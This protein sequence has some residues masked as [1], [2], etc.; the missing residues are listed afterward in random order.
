MKLTNDDVQDILK[1]LDASP[2]GELHLQTER[3]KLTLRRSA[4]GD[5]T[6]EQQVLTESNVEKGKASAVSKETSGD[7]T[8]SPS[9][10]AADHLVEISTPL[11]G[12]FYR[13]PKPGAPPFVEI[14]DRVEE[15]TVVAIIETMKLMS[16]INAG[17]SGTV[18]EICLKNA[19][20][21]E[22]DTVLIRIEPEAS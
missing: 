15:K 19:E 9:S 13:A 18:V 11:P 5:W 17:V 3:F 2:V 21:A 16:S 20:F 22:Q 6:Q 4:E 10:P 8:V 14:G 12:T 7:E 1:L